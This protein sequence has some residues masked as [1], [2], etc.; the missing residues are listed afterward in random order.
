ML[1]RKKLTLPL[2]IL[3]FMMTFTACSDSS[4]SVDN[5]IAVI[6]GS[7]ESSASQ[8]KVQ[9]SAE[10]EGAVVTAARVTSNGSFEVISETETQVSAS[11]NFTLEV[12]ASSLNH[13]AV[14]VETNGE[15][16]KGFLSKEISNGQTYTIK[17]VNSVSTAEAEVFAEIVAKGKTDIIHKSDIEAAVK[18]QSAAVIR[19]SSSASGQVASALESSAEA[20]FSFFSEYGDADAETKLDTWLTVMTEAQA[21]FESTVSNNSSADAHAAAFEALLDAKLFAYAETGLNEVEI[22]KLT[23]MQATVK[24]NS[25]NSAASDIRTDV[26]ASSSVLVALAVDKAVRT[27]A[28]A[29]GMSSATV[30]AIADAGAKLTGN[31]KASAGSRSEIQAAFDVYHEEVRNA[32]ESDSSVEGSVIVAI[33]IEINSTAGAKTIFNTAISGILNLNTMNEAY[34][35]FASSVRN[36]VEAQNSLIGSVETDAMADIL[37]MINLF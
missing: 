6:Q 31:V 3:L 25:L 16:L 28:E 35:E 15:T 2:V 26:R 9:S 30:S 4:V 18:N 17:P 36:S 7:V 11:G 5:N 37:L 34:A 22:S 10:A 24:Q 1:L 12:D 19:S 33:D 8:E 29:S 13:I 27:R 23:H 14:L 32:M 21:A 20:R